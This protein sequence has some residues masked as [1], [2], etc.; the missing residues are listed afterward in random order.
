M[1]RR[2]SEFILSTLDRAAGPPIG[3]SQEEWADALAARD[4]RIGREVAEAE[5]R[6]RARRVEDLV[7]R[8]VPVH[9][10]EL[11]LE[12][13]LEPTPALAAARRAV[14]EG[15]LVGVIG[16]PVGVG[17]TLAA[18]WWL[19]QSRSPAKVP[20]S[21]VRFLTAH[22]LARVSRYAESDMRPI[23]RASALVVDDL[24]VEFDDSAG[25]FRSLV[26]GLT[27]ARCNAGLPTLITTNMPPDAFRAR[28][29]DRVADRI[30]GGGRFV[31]VVGES[32][33]GRR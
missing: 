23:E 22:K 4:A 18:M 26:D 14:A 24:G 31:G 1:T 10:L 5:A 27:A 2:L 6:Y 15:W 29:G 13:R 9:E 11:V 19:V 8:G 17:K 32:L 16:G 28:Y 33:R 7:D 3:V 25:A 30:L 12:D 21:G 20:T